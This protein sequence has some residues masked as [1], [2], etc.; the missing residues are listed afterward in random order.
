MSEK[1]GLLYEFAGF[2][3][4][5]AQRILTR[6]RE[7]LALTPKVFETLL[8]LV[9]NSGKV[10][11]K[12]E[13][14]KTLWP[15]SFVEEGNL[16]QNISILRKTLG[17]DR[18]GN[19]L[20][21]TIPRRGYKFVAAVKEIDSDSPQSSLAADYWNC[22]TPFRSLQVFEPEDAWLFFG[23]DREISELLERLACA[24]VL[25]V[26]GNSGCGKSS[27]I[28]AGLLPALQTGRFCQ[29]GR[30][31]PWKIA[32]FRP[33][34]L[35]F[36][37][38]AEVLASQ[39]APELSMKEQAEFVADCR[40]K[41]P[42]DPKALRNAVIALANG[43][44]ERTNEEKTHVLLVADQFEELFTLTAQRE[45][46]DHYI[47]SIL[48]ASNSGGAIVVHV[49]LALRADFYAQCLEHPELGR[50]L[51]MNQYNVPRMNREQLRECI[52]RRL[53]LASASSEPGLI[54]A[55]LED[56]GE[57]PGNLALLEHALGQLWDRS[58]GFGRT[59]TNR[60]YSE[61]GRL[62]G[63]LGRH[64]DEV[65][66]SLGSDRLKLLARKIFLE[67]VHLGEDGDTTNSSDTRRRVS[68]AE[69][70][71]LGESEEIEQLLARLASSRLISTGGSE[72][73][74][75]VEVSHEALI[76]EWPALREWI[77]V[78]RDSLRLERRLRQAAEEWERVKRDSGALL[79]GAR[80]AQG[81]EWLVNSSESSIIVREFLQAS[82]A[83]RDEASR[84]KLA[85]SRWF[86]FA[87][88]IL[89]FV[90]LGVT[91]YVYRLQLV[92]KSRALAARAEEMR[93]RDQ[94][95]ALDLAISAWQTAKTDEAHLAVTRAFP[96][97][98]ATLNHYAGVESAVFSPDGQF[99]LTASDD[100]TA[101]IWNSKNGNL[102]ATLS[103]HDNKII[104]AEYSPNG[105]LI[106][107]S[108]FD[109]T[110]RVWSAKDGALRAVLAHADK[111]I[112]AH[113]SSDSQRIVT[114]SFDQTARV[115]SIDGTL[116]ATL[117]GHTNTIDWATFSSDGR[118]IITASYDHTA[119]LWN[120]TDYTLVAILRDHSNVV[121]SAEF[122]PDNQRVVTS[123]G[124]GTAR[125]WSSVDGHL[126]TILQHGGWV[127]RATFSPDGHRIA[128][129]STDRTGRVWDSENGLLLLTLQGH[130]GGV[131]HISF[132]PDGRLILTDS[133]DA[134]A[135]LWNADD[136]R[137]LVTLQPP[138][139]IALAPNEGFVA[140]WFSAFS[141][142]GHFVVASLGDPAARIWNITAAC[143]TLV[144]LQDHSGALRSI[145]SSH[146]GSY[147]STAALDNTARVW[148]AKNGR[149][150]VTLKG[151]SDYVYTATFSPD[152]LRVLTAS[153]DHTARI[154]SRTDGH[155]FTI[156]NGHSDQVLEGR[157]SPDGRRI[158]TASTDHTARLWDSE[159][160]HVVA[161]LE[162]HTNQLTGAQFSPNGKYIVTS[163]YDG[164]ARIWNQEGRLVTTLQGH[165][166]EI[167]HT[168]FS[169]DSKWVV[170]SSKDR[171]ARVWDIATGRSVVVLKG[172]T[173]IVSTA[174]FSPDGHLIVTSSY[175]G[176][177]RIW[178]SSDGHLLTVLEGHAGVLYF[179]A[180]SPDGQ[181]I[182]TASNDR[183][184]RLWES[185]N[186][187]L[188]A[189]LQGHTN[190]V[191]AVAYSHDGQRVA[192]ASYDGTARIWRIITLDD[193][194]RI[195]A[196]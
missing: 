82:I 85:R 81:E 192:T 190:V 169:P 43:A 17:D 175:D 125:L 196:E 170:T 22:H 112:R 9:Q 13:L 64:A 50:Q 117:Q 130:V 5:V 31:V 69:L 41:F 189:S 59:L 109:H 182:V 139:G 91:W 176:T 3:L 21:Q 113:F 164:I 143:R 11:E 76:R 122:S 88:G 194:Q 104:Y 83:A 177:A 179:A 67:L 86:S 57:E 153:K 10:L 186:G 65:Y 70:L 37:Y 61:I 110:A 188:V 193:L 152:D 62:R 158:V 163:G 126:M 33:S 96:Q 44:A 187:R 165:T 94:G 156:L 116:L 60:A 45:T 55:L 183:T 106:V 42:L 115:W 79:Q 98:I 147:I 15:D 132:S 97:L 49:V 24:P 66:A 102:L 100:H 2:R 29:E 35:P 154:W 90:A 103:G 136:G 19:G 23:R 145:E 162:G 68:K 27:L 47:D 180:F 7:P 32:V 25:A 34:V 46:R 92:E 18:N 52:E 4:D 141:P 105:E 121:T 63:A 173:G 93:G 142:D 87:F 172:H 53:R 157:F 151:H 8:V 74:P 39:L 134:S 48:S 191:S 168:S 30:P 120:G 14:M 72:Q 56:V 185:A 174:F 146:D 20:I 118:H 144:S 12:D 150:I 155:E 195:L 119:R 73:E 101:R 167:S 107:T 159:D 71:V 28:R 95:Q 58:G 6:N 78:H 171:T 129:A 54:D 138:P 114:S 166:D 131:G 148:D 135:R 149:L 133:A 108:S 80:L 16:S 38:L 89:L 124:D 99:V 40:S 184:A 161:V 128:T 51:G 77:A 140:P 127:D 181:R 123:S 160:G 36:D 111:L 1:T 178:S 137:L 26:V 84:A 75:F